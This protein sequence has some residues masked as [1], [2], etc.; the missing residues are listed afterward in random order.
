MQA[1]QDQSDL[2]LAFV[3]NRNSQAVKGKVNEKFILEDLTKV[4]E[5]YKIL[6][7][8]AIVCWNYGTFD[9]FPCRQFAPGWFVPETIFPRTVC[10][11]LMK[12]DLKSPAQRLFSDSFVFLLLG[13]IFLTSSFFLTG[14]FFLTKIKIKITN[15]RM[16]SAVIILH[17]VYIVMYMLQLIFIF[18]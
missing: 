15:Y 13:N 10:K 3:W 5:R 1:I 4:A 14:S 18:S 16:G 6:I 7:E 12:C 8:L 17:S 2:E 9:V 11:K